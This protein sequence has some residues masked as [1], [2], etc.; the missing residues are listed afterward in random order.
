M[1]YKRVIAFRVLCNETFINHIIYLVCRC[2]GYADV[3]SVQEDIRW[4]F[5]AAL[6]L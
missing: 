3:I 5:S 1:K 4:Q 6:V 2:H